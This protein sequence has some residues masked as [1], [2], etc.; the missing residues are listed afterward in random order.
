VFAVPSLKFLGHM[1][2]EAGIT[3]LPWHVAAVQDCLTLTDIKQLQRFLGLINFYRRF[4]PAV[5]RTLQPLTDLLKGSPK[6]LLWSPASDAAFVA[7]KAALVAAVPLC[8]PAPQAVFSLAVDASDLHVGGVLRQKCGRGWQP[9]AFY[10]KSSLQLRSGIPRSTG[11]SSRPSS[12]SGTSVFCLK[13][14]SSRS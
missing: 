12:P 3:P 4:L 9:L 7:T 8:H 5:A 11:S 2:D 10:S 14:G 6:V 1:V 13:A